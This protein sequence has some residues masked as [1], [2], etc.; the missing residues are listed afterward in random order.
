MLVLGGI[1]ASAHEIADAAT[2]AYSET[3]RPAASLMWQ[4]AAAVAGLLSVIVM[5]LLL[6][7]LKAATVLLQRLFLCIGNLLQRCMPEKDEDHIVMKMTRE[8]HWLLLNAGQ[9]LATACSIYRGC[10]I[11][12]ND[13]FRLNVD[14]FRGRS[15]LPREAGYGLCA[16][17]GCFAGTWVA[18][19]LY[20]LQ[21]D[22]DV[23][24]F[25]AAAEA[26][27]GAKH[28][29]ILRCVG[30]TVGEVP[31]RN[32]LMDIAADSSAAEH[33]V[34]AAAMA[35]ER[36]MQQKPFWRRRQQSAAVY[37]A[38]AAE[39]GM[40]VAGC[41]LLQL[42][43]QPM[44]LLAGLQASTSSSN[45]SSS[46]SRPSSAADGG[47]AAVPECSSL[48]NW[49]SR[50]QLAP[51]LVAGVQHLEQQLQ[52]LSTAQPGAAAAAAAAAQTLPSLLST[53]TGDQ[54]AAASVLDA[55]SVPAQLKLNP[56]LLLL[57]LQQQ[58]QQD[59]AHAASIAGASAAGAA[60][61]GLLPALA[62]V[63]LMLL[64]GSSS[65]A[66]R[67]GRSMQQLQQPAQT[68]QAAELLPAS[69]QAALDAAGLQIL[70]QLLQQVAGLLAW[71]QDA[72]TQQ[73]QHAVGRLPARSTFSVA[74][75][76]ALAPA[77]EASEDRDSMSSQQQQQQ[78]QASH[79]CGALGS[80]AAAARLGW[81]SWLVRRGSAQ[82][83]HAAA[84]TAVGSSSSTAVP[85]SS[86]SAGAG[87]LAAGAS[88]PPAIGTSYKDWPQLLR[89]L[90][91][92]ADKA[93]AWQQQQQQRA[94]K[95]GSCSCEPPSYF[96]CPI[97]AAVMHDPVVAA[98]GFTY[99]RSAISRW[100]HVQGMRR[101]PMTNQPMEAVLVPNHSLRSSI[102]EWRQQ[103]Q[104]HS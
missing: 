33:V 48:A 102:M 49:S 8:Q 67:Q 12:W 16:Y 23:A 98:D 34:Q 53:L 88:Q 60:A 59:A 82:Q 55:A 61:V 18:A 24:R 50:L 66:G 75:A 9:Q 3:L 57:G 2:A 94:T 97:T 35:A 32:L 36:E 6:P 58:L 7:L 52:Q 71:Q 91:Q 101:S 78:Q 73:Q 39:T 95:P 87:Q 99:E 22:R 5:Y 90:Q 31:V 81:F 45:G 26:C 19:Q 63:L 51:Q 10:C 13:K 14:Y 15:R 30:A 28:P 93:T 11:A 77:E 80:G 44:S 85:A 65:A 89:C 40:V 1:A 21:D 38:V 43:E 84:S 29:Q 103:Q 69:E 79:L 72:I 96:V 83:Q 47:A 37:K 54:L 76:E 100:L 27:L 56:A 62:D 64:S 4:L 42:P 86:S 20:V 92:L 74:A 70:Q 104:Q 25:C 41:L 17:K 46:S 68:Q